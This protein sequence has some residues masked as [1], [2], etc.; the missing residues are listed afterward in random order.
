MCDYFNKIISSILMNQ[1]S[2]PT[3]VAAMFSYYIFN[4]LSF[5]TIYFEDQ[6]SQT[7]LGPL[8]DASVAFFLFH[9]WSRSFCSEIVSSSSFCV[10]VSPSLLESFL[11]FWD[12]QF[13]QLAFYFPCS[14]HSTNHCETQG[15]HL[16]LLKRRNQACFQYIRAL[17]KHF[18]SK[19]EEQEVN[20]ERSDQ[21]SGEQTQIKINIVLKKAKDLLRF[22]SSQMNS[23]APPHDNLPKC[24]QEGQPQETRNYFWG[25]RVHPSQSCH[26]STVKAV[27]CD[28]LWVYLIL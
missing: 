5:F 6:C 12:S 23:L 8:E 7:C 17:S 25:N 9:S 15:N 14:D 20:Q 4:N 28:S 11:L 21:S 1:H 2:L 16:T 18:C 26:L 27:N 13:F 10:F 22:T 24:G 3:N 19:K